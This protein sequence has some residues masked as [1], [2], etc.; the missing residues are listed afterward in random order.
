MIRLLRK[1]ETDAELTLKP[2]TYA[3]AAIALSSIYARHGNKADRDT[4]IDC[5]DKSL[6]RLP[7]YGLPYAMKLEVSMIDFKKAFDD[8]DKQAALENIR[9][10][11]NDI[12]NNQSHALSYE[13][14][15]R[16]D[17]QTRSSHICKNPLTI[18]KICLQ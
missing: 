1:Y 3:N 18:S 11:F 7:N 9:R 15:E 14:I 5:C 13:I 16:L 10:T 2:S 6:S 12:K 8:N 4:C 17:L